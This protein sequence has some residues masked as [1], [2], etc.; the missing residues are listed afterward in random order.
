MLTDKE[1]PYGYKLIKEATNKKGTLKAKIRIIPVEAV[2]DFDLTIELA[3]SLE[4]VE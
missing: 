4:I 2:E 3:D 1:V